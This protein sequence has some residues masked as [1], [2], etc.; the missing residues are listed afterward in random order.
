MLPRVSA[1]SS[2]SDQPRV[3]SAMQRRVAGHVRQPGRH[4]IAAVEVAAEPDVL[5]AR[6]PRGR[7]R[8][9]RPPGPPSRPAPDAAARTGPPPPVRGP[10]AAVLAALD[11]LGHAPRDPI[12]GIRSRRTPARTSPCTRRRCRRASCSTSSGTLRRWSTSARAEEWLKITGAEDVSSASPHRGRRD[13]REVD[14]HAERVHLAHDVAAEV[15]QPAAL[16]LVGGRVRPR[17]VV[18]VRQRHVAHAERVQHAQHGERAVDAVPALGAEQRRD[19]ALGV[20]ALDIG[21]RRAPASSRSGW[22]ATIRSTKS[23]CSSV[24]VTAR[25]AGQIARHVHRP[26]LPA[27]SAVDE[28]D[29]IG[30][31]LVLPLVERGSR[32]CRSR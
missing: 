27:D 31:G 29:E 30:A 7:G 3:S 1:A 16:R 2:V 32:R 11:H 24:A 15:G 23:I 13:V 22:C 21:R 4:R 28:P 9:G 5:D 8:R 17:Q 19:P 6:R 25:V 20:G 18:V 14:E 12:R 26:E 10:V